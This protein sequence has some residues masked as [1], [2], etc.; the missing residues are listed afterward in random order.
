MVIDNLDMTKME[1]SQVKI[2]HMPKILDVDMDI[3]YV[4]KFQCLWCKIFSVQNFLQH[5]EITAKH[6]P[7]GKLMPCS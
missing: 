2:H 3:S 6:P 7:V 5:G 1:Q 4:A